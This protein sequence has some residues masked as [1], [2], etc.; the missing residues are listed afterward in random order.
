MRPAVATL[1]HAEVQVRTRRILGPLSLDV[2]EGELLGVVGPNGAGKSTLLRVL[3]GTQ[4][5]AGGE[6]K[7]LGRHADG[8]VP[9]D[10]GSL[11]GLV[12]YLLQHHHFAADL[13][14]TVHDVVALGALPRVQRLWG[15]RVSQAHDRIDAALDRLGLQPLRSSL[16]RELSGGERQK[17]Q[18][19][20]LLVQD[21]NLLLLDEPTAGLDPDWQERLTTM[22]ADLHDERGRTMIM[23]THDISRLPQCCDRV[24]L[25]RDGKLR[26]LGPT[27][28]VLTEEAL[29]NVYGCRMAVVTREGR[30]HAFS[31]SGGEA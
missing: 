24:L 1:T 4:P 30:Y 17:V 9:L 27:A 7:L 2:R 6:L 23:V 5:L 14:F 3:T 12:G 16:Y 29:S 26:A 15:W 11:R 28:E 22:I 25:L 21:A 19:A 8:S 31:C 13:P 10:A 20:R 18:I